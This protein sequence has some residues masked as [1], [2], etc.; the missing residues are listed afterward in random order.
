M[1]S[2]ARDLSLPQSNQ[3]HLDSNP[4]FGFPAELRLAV[5]LPCYNEEAAV[6]QVISDFSIALPGADIYVFDN[7]ST[8][9]TVEKARKAGAIVR[10]VQLPGKGNVVRRMFADVD[11]DVYVM[12]D[13]D[14]TYHAPSAPEMIRKLVRDNLDMIVGV[15]EHESSEAYRR[16]HMAG[17]RLLTYT[18]SSIF[19]NGFTDMLSGYRV[20]SRRF[21]KSFPAMSQ[22][23]EIETELAIHALELRIPCGEVITPYGV[24]PE[25]SESKLSTYSDGFRIIK[26]ILKLFVTERPLR[27]YAMAAALLIITAVILAVPIVVTYIDTGLVPRFPTAILSTGLVIS[28][29]ISF[30]AGLI[31][32]TVTIGRREIKRLHYLSISSVA[33]QLKS[34]S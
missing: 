5:V 8:D 34:G 22:G 31:L 15:R 18:M 7:S 12:A 27:F 11:A 25:D 21:V 1:E 10:Q 23:F 9:D 24:R 16:G 6:T 28:G 3:Y 17:N 26:T 32:E 14:A 4:S 33:E 20:F 19:G 13:G 2:P 30:V 29:V